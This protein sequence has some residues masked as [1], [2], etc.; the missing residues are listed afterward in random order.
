[1]VDGDEWDKATAAHW[2]LLLLLLIGLV[3]A[4]AIVDHMVLLIDTALHLRL[5]AAREDGEGCRSEERC[6]DFG[7][8]FHQRSFC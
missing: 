7:R 8:A 2:A 1:V 3:G 4:E 5:A 6:S